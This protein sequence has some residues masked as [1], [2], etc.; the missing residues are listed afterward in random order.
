MN[1]K[2]KIRI[3]ALSLA[4]G[5]VAMSYMV[6]LSIEFNAFYFPD[7]YSP[8]DYLAVLVCCVLAIYFFVVAYY[9]SFKLK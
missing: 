4:F 1:Q 3:C 6:Y 5:L 8:F 2:R 9:G 7:N